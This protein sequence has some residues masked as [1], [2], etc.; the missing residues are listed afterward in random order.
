MA[1]KEKTE[2]RRFRTTDD[3]WESFGDA[4]ERGPDPE[5]DMSKVLRA[6]VRWYVGEPGAKLPERP[7]PKDGAR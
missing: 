4:V 3:L 1:A 2:V 7:E 6:F 5:A